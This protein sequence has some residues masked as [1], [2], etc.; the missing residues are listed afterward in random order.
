MV[1]FILTKPARAPSH[2]NPAATA[3]KALIG[4]SEAI[5]SAHANFVGIKGMDHQAEAAYF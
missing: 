5:R 2:T 3:R 1:V 4:T